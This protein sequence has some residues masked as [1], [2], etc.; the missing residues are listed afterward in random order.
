MKKKLFFER[1][2]TLI[3]A[4]VWTGSTNKIFGDNVWVTASLPSQCMGQIVAPSC[5]I[6]ESGYKHHPEYPNVVDQDFYLEIFIENVGNELGRSAMM[7]GNRTT[8][9]SMGAGALDIDSEVMT[10]IIKTVSMTSSV[11]IIETAAQKA[12]MVSGNHPLLWRVYAFNVMLE[13]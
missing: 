8:N 6:V 9:K 4:M 5:F 7:G 2:E 3:K 1:L 13:V 11:Q 12:S 10:Q